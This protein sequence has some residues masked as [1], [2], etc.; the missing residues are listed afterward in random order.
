M[1][2]NDIHDIKP[3]VDFPFQF[4]F[5]YIMI[6]ILVFLG[7]FGLI[8]FLK[9]KG[10]KTTPVADPVKSPREIALE[11]LE[12]LHQETFLARG[13]FNIFYSKLSDIVRHY[14]EGQFQIKAPEMTTEEFLS[15]LRA[16]RKLLGQQ[17]EVLESFLT[18]CD[19]VKFAKYAPLMSEAEESFGLAKNIVEE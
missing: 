1:P 9:K 6:G 10:R 4:N 17:K 11:Q 15:S 16:S 13:K 18:S 19:M 12:A 8:Y 14:F 2:V 7:I 5:I 3:P